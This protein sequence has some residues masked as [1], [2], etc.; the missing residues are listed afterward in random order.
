MILVYVV[1]LIGLLALVWYLR[2]RK[3]YLPVVFNYDCSSPPEFVL[4]IPPKP[5]AREQVLISAVR[6]IAFEEGVPLKEVPTG[7]PYPYEFAALLYQN[8]YLW[9]TPFSQID[10]GAVRKAVRRHKVCYSNRIAFR[11]EM[12]SRAVI[13][14]TPP[15]AAYFEDRSPYSAAFRIV[16][17]SDISVSNSGEVNVHDYGFLYNEFLAE[18]LEKIGG[19]VID[20]R[21]WKPYVVSVYVKSPRK[22]GEGNG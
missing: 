16:P 21:D 11:N 18:E 9:L 19:G 15:P 12:Y 2:Q 1:L 8:R 6:R 5:S 7:P 4:L 20:M 17:S 3:E 22:E 10:Y 14:Y 13:A